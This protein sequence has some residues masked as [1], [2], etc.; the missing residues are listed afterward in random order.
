MHQQRF[1]AVLIENICAPEVHS[2]I[3]TKIVNVD[4][5]HSNSRVNVKWINMMQIPTGHSV[6]GAYWD[7]YYAAL[8]KWEEA[9]WMEEL[10]WVIRGRCKSIRVD[11]I[12]VLTTWSMQLRINYY[13]THGICSAYKMMQTMLRHQIS[14]EKHKYEEKCRR[15]GSRCISAIASVR[16]RLAIVNCSH[17]SVWIAFFGPCFHLD[18][19]AWQLQNHFFSCI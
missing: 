18:A 7:W 4:E 16:A 6:N 19:N 2:Q 12:Y 11:C 9:Q 1:K 14:N 15:N 3:I 8:W 13:D 17:F 5:I 10:R